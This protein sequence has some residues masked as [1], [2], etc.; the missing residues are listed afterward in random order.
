MYYKGLK[1]STKA[2]SYTTGGVTQAIMDKAFNAGGRS[3][4]E[5]DGYGLGIR[6][7]A[8]RYG[9]MLGLVKPVT[10]SLKG[11]TFTAKSAY[12]M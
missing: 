7:K 1:Y 10:L 3:T 11:D 9:A 6:G 12:S 2:I 4:I 8:L 5:V